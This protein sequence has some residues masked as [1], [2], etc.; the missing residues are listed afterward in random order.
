MN[1]KKQF[2]T[3][4]FGGRSAEHDISI[5]SSTAVYRNLDRRR[6]APRLIYINRRGDWRW[7]DEK[8]MTAPSADT[9]SR[10]SFQSILPWRCSGTGLPQTDICFPILHGPNGEDGRVPALLE[11]ADIPFVGAGSQGSALAMDKGTAKSLFRAA[12]ILTPDF[13][14]F[15]GDSLKVISHRVSERMEW[16]VF[17]KPCN[18][19]SSVGISKVKTAGELPAAVK[20]AYAHDSRIIVEQGIRGREIEVAVMGNDSLEVSQPGE[21]QPHNEFYDYADKYLDGK[22][23]FSIPAELSEDT[24]DEIRGLAAEA[25]RSLHLFGLSRVDFFLESTG[26]ILVNEINTMPGFTEISMF[27]KLFLLEGYTFQSLVTRLIDYGLARH[28]AGS[29]RR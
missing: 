19:G 16:P 22:T 4:L 27:P 18:L 20:Q 9:L 12:G 8:E 1:Q 7:V 24:A 2:V 10:G 21:L 3:I 14:V 13:L 5:L 25:F 6:F 29:T 28:A 15:A 17:V 11:L 23:R 26:R